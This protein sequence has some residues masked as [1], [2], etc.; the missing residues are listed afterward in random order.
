MKFKKVALVQAMTSLVG[1]EDAA[2]T[3]YLELF[4]FL[5]LSIDLL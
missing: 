5:T 4:P 2:F 1:V 3:S